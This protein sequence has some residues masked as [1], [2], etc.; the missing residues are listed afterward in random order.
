MAHRHRDVI[1]NISE[2]ENVHT[3]V[4]KAPAAKFPTAVSRRPALKDIENK[5][6]KKDEEKKELKAEVLKKAPLLKSYTSQSL[7][8]VDPDVDCKDEPQMVTEYLEDIFDYLREFQN[9]FPIKGTFLE[10]HKSTPR[11]RSILVNWL[12]QVHSNF[13]LCLETL[14]MSISILDRYLQA[15]KLIGRE[16]LQLVGAAALL[17]ACKYEEIYLPNLGDF[18]Y[19][20]DD[21]FT[22]KQILQTE[23]DILQVLEFN[24]G[25]PISIL[26]L[27]RY[28]KI[29]G[30]KSDQHTLA[31]YILEQA[32]LD[33]KFS[34][35]DPSTQAAAACC[36]AITITNTTLTPYPSK[37]WTPT[38]AHYTKHT[39]DD[40]KSTVQS[41]ANMILA[42]E[43]TKYLAVY[44]KYQASVYNKI[45]LLPKRKHVVVKKLAEGWTKS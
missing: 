2:R 41:F 29:G 25:K 7:D 10:G 15:N 40:L 44:N 30:V 19:V 27:R 43:N 32:L 20:C 36:L 18:S 17:I 5:D 8:I 21:V 45:A 11:M 16:S 33:H 39:Y 22:T 42:V 26:F 23:R 14:H 28:S 34:H 12:V 38:L 35:I 9:K 37:N 13:K 31:K 3:R 24:L 1:S 6:V 4:G